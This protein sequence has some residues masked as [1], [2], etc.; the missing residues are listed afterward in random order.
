MQGSCQGTFG[1]GEGSEL[2]SVY[3]SRCHRVVSNHFVYE[4][5]KV[6]SGLARVPNYLA[7]MSEHAS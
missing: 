2:P 4:S 5:G 7:C 3:I 6:L 1:V